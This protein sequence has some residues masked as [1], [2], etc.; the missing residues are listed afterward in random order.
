MRAFERVRTKKSNKLLVIIGVALFLLP[1]SGGVILCQKNRIRRMT[2]TAEN[3]FYAMKSLELEI[4]KVEDTVLRQANPEQLAELRAKREK[5]LSM[6]KDYD[7]LVK[8]LGIYRKMSEEDRLILRTAHAL[9]ECELTVPTG[10]TDE[11]KNYILKWKST[12]R[13]ETAIDRAKSKGYVPIVEHVLAHYG[14]SAHYFFLAVRESGFKY[15][16]VGPF[17]RDGYA[18]GVWQ[19]IPTTATAYGLK[20]GPLAAQ[21]LYDPRDER[22]NFERE[23]KAAAEYIKDIRDIVAQASGLLVLVTYNWGETNA[24]KIIDQMPENPRERNFWR[25]IAIENIPQQAYD[26][27]FY[28]FSAAVICENPRLFGFD[29]EC[30][31]TLQ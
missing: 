4:A 26:Y 14:L 2:S 17:T 8:D 23:T 28:V 31:V 19:L 11:V 7:R 29:F 27:V 9:R 3:L 30:P 1:A 20:L 18:K 22:F 16:A 21:P 12:D 24:Q 6:E 15:H 13:L 5:L 25:F 10:F